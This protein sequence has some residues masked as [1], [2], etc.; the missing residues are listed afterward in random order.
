MTL[1]A[2]ATAGEGEGAVAGADAVGPLATTGGRE[3]AIV[4]AEALGRGLS[5]PATAAAT[6]SPRHA[7]RMRVAFIAVTSLE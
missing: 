4:G 2:R 5:Q 1:G 6:K 3:G 7:W